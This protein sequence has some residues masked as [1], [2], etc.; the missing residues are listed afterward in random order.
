[1]EASGPRTCIFRTG[2]TIALAS[3]LTV[4]KPFITIAG[5]TAP[6]GGIQLRGP[7]SAGD[8]ALMVTTHDVVIQYLRVRRGHNAGEICNQMPWS[9]GASMEIFSGA[10]GANPYNIML[11]HLSVEWSNYD[12]VIG[13]GSNNTTTQP[14]SLTISHSI[15]GEALGGAGQAVGANFSG[16]SGQGSTVPDGMTDLDLHHNLF[17][18]STHRMPIMTVRSARLVN[19]IVYAWTYYAMRGKGLRDFISNYFTTRSGQS[20]ASHEVHAWTENAGNDTSLAPSFYL[21]GNVGPSDPA[22]TNNW[23]MT[24]LAQSGAGPEAS[25]PLAAIY[26]RGSPMPTPSGYVPITA[27]PVSMISSAAGPM[28]NTARAAP[29]DGVGASRKLTCTGG[30][31]DA[32]D[33]VDSR[34]VNAVANRTNLYGSYD[35][36]SV[37]AAPQSQADLGGWPTLAP[38][39]ACP[40]GNGNGLPDAWESYWAGVFGLAGALDPSALNFGDGYTNLEHY[41]SGISPSQP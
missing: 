10:P 39:T 17:A 13:L 22:G 35:Y 11:D 26:Q 7:N 21:I 30:W 3:S 31:Q 23:T 25:S 20:A 41:L 29:F 34:I 33:P 6:G 19:N 9:C 2:G 37:Q 28:L 38:G 12:A 8:P 15:I 32:Q 4:A 16:Y 40:D 36:S 14:R 5:Q 27:D 1:V 24:G 18:G